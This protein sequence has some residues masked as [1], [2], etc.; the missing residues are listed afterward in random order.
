VVADLEH[1]N[2]G[3]L[4]ALVDGLQNARLRI[5]SQKYR[6]GRVA[7]YHHDARLV[8]GCVLHRAGWRHHIELDGAHPQSIAIDQLL[9]VPRCVVLGVADHRD[10]GLQRAGREEDDRDASD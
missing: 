4:A 9:H 6:L 1:V 5:S 10:I 8:S 2:S 3:Q 7:G